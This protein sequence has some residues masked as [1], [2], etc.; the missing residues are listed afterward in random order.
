MFF[1]TQNRQK[2]SPKRILFMFI[3]NYFSGKTGLRIFFIPTEKMSF[4]QRSKWMIVKWLVGNSSNENGGNERPTFASTFAFFRPRTASS[5]WWSTSTV[6]TSCS[7]FS[8]RESL[9]SLA[10]DSIRR[11]SCWRYSFCTDT[12]SFT[13]VTRMRFSWCRFPNKTVTCKDRPR[14]ARLCNTYVCKKCFNHCPHAQLWSS[15][16]RN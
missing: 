2:S 7:R 3:H 9:T 4:W 1:E 11:K 13:G 8:A 5:S 15:C 10:Q 16:A 6:A 14:L 12:A